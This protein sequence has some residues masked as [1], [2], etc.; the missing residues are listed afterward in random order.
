MSRRKLR[1]EFEDPEMFMN[2]RE[3]DE[4]EL[5]DYG[6]YMHAHRMMPYL[7]FYDPVFCGGEVRRSVAVIDAVKSDREQLMRA[8]AILGHSPCLE[9]VKAL[10]AYGESQRPLAGVA[11]LALDECSMMFARLA[12]DDL[13]S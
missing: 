3:I 2:V 11:R 7:Y 8:L 9:A 5:E 4:D 10:R 1:V 6:L 12:I 13:A